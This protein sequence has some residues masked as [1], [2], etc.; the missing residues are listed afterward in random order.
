MASRLFA[1]V[2]SAIGISYGD[3]W[4][5]FGFTKKIQNAIDANVARNNCVKRLFENKRPNELSQWNIPSD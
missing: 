1:G 3:F 5:I 2:E 4:E